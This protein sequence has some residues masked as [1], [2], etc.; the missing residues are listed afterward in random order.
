MLARAA[1]V[2]HHR[3]GLL[4]ML[5][6]EQQIGQFVDR[7][8]IRFVAIR[9]RI[10]GR[11]PEP[12]HR[13]IET[14]HLPLQFRRGVVGLQ[15]PR[16]AVAGTGAGMGSRFRFKS[17]SQ[18]KN[19][20]QKGYKPLYAWPGDHVSLSA[21]RFAVF[22]LLAEMQAF[23]WTF[24]APLFMHPFS[25]CL[26]CLP[27]LVPG[28][29]PAKATLNHSFGHHFH[30]PVPEP[31][32]RKQ[33]PSSITLDLLQLYI[34]AEV[35][36]SGFCNRSV[37]NRSVAGVS[38]SWRDVDRKISAISTRLPEPR[39]CRALSGAAA[40]R[41]SS[42]RGRAPW[43]R[44]ALHPSCRKMRVRSLAIPALRT[45]P[46]SVVDRVSSP[47]PSRDPAAPPATD[48]LPPLNS[49]SQYGH[50]PE[51]RRARRSRPTS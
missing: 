39:E 29:F 2:E 11:P 28:I 27:V 30:N 9:V 1:E 8:S 48:R 6:R 21:M 50:D 34:F 35:K 33:Q 43:E 51:K 41:E 49:N 44:G 31:I 25:Y 24:D 4:P 45:P 16:V 19:R 5:G 26:P 47:K 12:S 23:A 7:A 42:R 13:Q 36:S 40:P 15:P 18:Q 3:D 32:M 10:Y 22:A 46:C 20:T 37:S 17:G 38:A 14:R